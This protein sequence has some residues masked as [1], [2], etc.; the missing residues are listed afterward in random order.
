LGLPGAL[1]V[2]NEHA[3]ELSARVGLA[4][5]CTIASRTKWDRKSYFYPDLPKAYQISQYDQPVCAQGS[6]EVLGDDGASIRTV[7][8]LRA[9]L[10]EDAG[11]L[12]HEAP[13]GGAIDGSLVDLNRAG[14]ALLEIVTEPDFR[15]GEECERFARS[16]RRLCRHLGATEGVMQ[17]GHMRFEPNINL[18]LTLA[19]GAAVRTPIVEV[20]NLNSFRALRGAVEYEAGAQTQRWRDDGRVFGTGTKATRGWDE[21][22]GVTTP[23]R[24]KEDAHDYRY[25]PDPDLP[26]IVLDDAWIDRVR[27]DLCEHPDARLR[28]WMSDRGLS[29]KDAEALIEERAT[30][31]LYDAAVDEAPACARTVTNLLLQSAAK[32]ANERGV[33]LHALGLTATQVA[34][35]ARLRDDGAVSAAA[36]DELIGLVMSGGEDADE[37]P[38]RI[39]ERRG[40]VVVRDESQLAAWCDEVLAEFPDIARQIRD[41]KAQAAGRLIGAVMKKSGGQADAKRVR[42]M[43]LERIGS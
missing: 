10:E 13:G 41:G 34:T 20:K 38:A 17:A 29:M 21:V 11:K 19:D 4:L 16:L 42:E 18:E 27:A 23:Q 33:E 39:A 8:I 15:T 43:L 30:A 14:T 3:V 31:D 2:L 7:R 32:R 37:D 6:V 28:R 36:A 5:G 24:E 9:H 1:P 26:E 40:M 25:F 35:I 12:L 22:R